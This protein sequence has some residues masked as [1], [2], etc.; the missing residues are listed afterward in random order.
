MKYRENVEWDEELDIA[1]LKDNY[2]KDEAFPKVKKHPVWGIGRAFEEKVDEKISEIADFI[3][4][5]FSQIQY[6]G[7]TNQVFGQQALK[8]ALKD[9]PIPNLDNILETMYIENSIPDWD[10]V[11]TKDYL[12][13][14]RGKIQ[15]DLS[16]LSLRLV[17]RYKRIM[18]DQIDHK[19]ERRRELLTDYLLFNREYYESYED[20]L[21][22]INA[23]M[24]I[25]K[26]DISASE[27]VHKEEVLSERK[28][29]LEAF[30]FIRGLL[31]SEHN[32]V[33]RYLK[34]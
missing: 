2:D 11:L 30:T 18:R 12:Q 4:P 29:E 24:V 5:L 33:E 10:Y 31:L 21:D 7:V 17:S 6:S 25:L 34:S 27:K 8:E 1:K 32:F 20:A 22:F 15:M 9:Y 16:D 13:K 23:H 19:L 14:E 26:F 3:Y 28:L